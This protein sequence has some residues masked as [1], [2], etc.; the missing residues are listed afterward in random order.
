MLFSYTMLV[1]VFRQFKDKW[2]CFSFKQ[3]IA[4][5]IAAPLDCVK[6]KYDDLSIN[7]E[8]FLIVPYDGFSIRFDTFATNEDYI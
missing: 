4:E 7:S 6:F 8:S 2:R 1:M 5:H 3:F